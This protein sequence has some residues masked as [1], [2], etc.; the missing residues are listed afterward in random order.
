MMSSRVMPSPQRMPRNPHDA[1]A[2]QH[3]VQALQHRPLA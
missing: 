2:A 3:L 1:A